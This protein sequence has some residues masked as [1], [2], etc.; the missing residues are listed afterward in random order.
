[1]KVVARLLAKTPFDG[2]S[3][4]NYRLE[5]HRNVQQEC[6]WSCG[7]DEVTLDIL[8]M[9]VTDLSGANAKVVS[10]V[11]NRQELIAALEVFK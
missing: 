9:V 11:V 2:T 10:F 4:A 5:V 3:Q 7:D 8:P 1:M 6:L